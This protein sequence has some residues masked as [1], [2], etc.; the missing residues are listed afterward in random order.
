MRLSTS[1]H[2]MYR[3]RGAGEARKCLR[4]RRQRTQRA[5]LHAQEAWL[6]LRESQV[7][8]SLVLHTRQEPPSASR[9][10]FSLTALFG[11]HQ[12]QTYAL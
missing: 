11:A 2:R 7:L 9:S 8:R 1:P 4:V 10:R 3:I 12:A 5:T 6:L